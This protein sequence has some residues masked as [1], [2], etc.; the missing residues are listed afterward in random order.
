VLCRAPCTAVAPA[1]C[2]WPCCAACWAQPHP[3]QPSLP[4][5]LSACQLARLPARPP[6]HP[7]LRWYLDR[8]GVGDE[9]RVVSIVGTRAPLNQGHI[10]VLFR[11][12]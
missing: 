12:Y 9:V 8:L 11:V 5:C 4:A 6:T 10:Q 3:T 1:G 2:G 7:S